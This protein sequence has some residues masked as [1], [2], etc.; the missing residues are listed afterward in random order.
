MSDEADDTADADDEPEGLGEIVVDA[1]V[2]P[3]SNSPGG[4]EPLRCPR[5][6]T[7]IAL[8]VSYGPLTHKAT[9]CGCPVPADLLERT[10]G[11]SV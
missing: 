4:R 7:A 3:A 2:I 6:D 8:V 11:D 1:D 5:C 9:P 10:D